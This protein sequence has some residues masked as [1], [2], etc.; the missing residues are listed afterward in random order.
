MTPSTSGPST[1]KAAAH[2]LYAEGKLPH[3]SVSNALRLAPED[4]LHSS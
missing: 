3:M 4:Y 2:R 1:A